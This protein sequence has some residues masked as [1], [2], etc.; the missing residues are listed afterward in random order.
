MRAMVKA[1]PDSEVAGILRDGRATQNLAPL[2]EA[3]AR[4]RLASGTGWANEVPLGPVP[5]ISLIDRMVE[6]QTARD[7][8]ELIEKEA[9]RLAKK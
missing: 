9:R 7:T 8:A 1:V 5:G 6:V 2:G 3:N 4:P